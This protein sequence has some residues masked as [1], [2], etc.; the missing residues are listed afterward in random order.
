[1]TAERADWLAAPERGSRLLLRLMARLS[2]Y[3]GRAA[4]RVPLH[5]ITAYFYLFSPHA[6]RAARRYQRRAL[7]R[8][9]TCPERYRQFA[10][11]ATTIHDR[12]F[13]ANGRDHLFEISV[14][15]EELMR[16]QAATGRGAILLGAHLGSF[17]VVGAIGRRLGGV[18]ICMA[19]YEENARKIRDAMAS[20]APGGGPDVVALGR[21]DAM[22][23]IS[24]RLD[25]GA[26]VGILGDRTFGD[27]PLQAVTL[28]GERAGL[29][30]GPMRIAAILGCPVIFMAG[31]YRGANRYHVVFEKV[32]DFGAARRAERGAQVTVAVERYARLLDLRCRS[33]PQNWFNFYEFW[34]PSGARRHG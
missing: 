9:P 10:Y 24:E 25:A 29:P 30:T 23:Q 3:V 21:V 16:A 4:S 2:L 19:M 31:L 27:E 26:F 7:G 8:E 11:F 5:A 22:L 20:I 32:A 1:M 17:D 14:D 34:P 15:G 33:D 6:R 12:V 13:L 28:L 18:R